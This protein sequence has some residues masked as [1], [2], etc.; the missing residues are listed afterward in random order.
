MIN[1]ALLCFFI[2]LNQCIAI[3]LSLFFIIHNTRISY[4]IFGKHDGNAHIWHF[5]SLEMAWDQPQISIFSIM[6]ITPMC[7]VMDENAICNCQNAIY[8]TLRDASNEFWTHTEFPLIDNAMTVTLEIKQT[9][10]ISVTRRKWRCPKKTCWG[11]ENMKLF[12]GVLWTILNLVIGGIF[13]R[14]FGTIKVCMVSMF[15]A[16]DRANVESG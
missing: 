8:E 16:Y 2:S 12:V 1:W 5:V 15:T 14:R 10:E 7:T 3:Y 11:A 9:D 4:G 13:S 6:I